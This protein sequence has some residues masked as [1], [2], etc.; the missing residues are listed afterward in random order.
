MTIHQHTRTLVSNYIVSF[1]VITTEGYVLILTKMVLLE[2][3]LYLVH[4]TQGK[5]SHCLYSLL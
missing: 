1:N 2:L 3:C 4:Q 5:S